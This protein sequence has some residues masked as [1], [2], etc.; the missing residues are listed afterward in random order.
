[1]PNNIHGFKIG[2]SE[3][4]YDY[5]YLA[6]KPEG[7]PVYDTSGEDNGK[8][9]VVY[10]N[11]LEW[12]EIERLPDY[13]SGDQNK[14]L[15]VADSSL[16]PLSGGVDWVSPEDLNIL[17]NYSAY[18]SNKVLGLVE[19]ESTPE[20]AWVDFLPAYDTAS[21]EG[22]KVLG[23]SDD[24]EL[25]WQEILPQQESEYKGL[26]LTA[27][28]SGHVSWDSVLP[29]YDKEY[30]SDSGKSLTING[31]S[32]E[33]QT[34]LPAYD[35]TYQDEGKVLAITNN[36]LAWTEII[37]PYDSSDAGKVLSVNNDGELEWV[38]P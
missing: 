13:T 9:L 32:I 16:D 15:V 28:G 18:D 12:Q 30:D 1:M 29:S 6:N 19:G 31:N 4:Q 38:T 27:D 5:D 10:D 23:L 20:L 36:E 35:T 11:A 37:P 33:W 7:I 3:Y 22:G 17:P 14:V 26:V 24:N 21:Q 34:I 2:S 25:V 8:S